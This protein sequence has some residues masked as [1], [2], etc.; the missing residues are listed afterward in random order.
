VLGNPF[1]PVVFDAACL[2]WN[3][4]TIP[5]MAQAIYDERHFDDLSILADALEES[6]CDNEALLS[7]CRRAGPHVRGCWAVDLILS[8]DR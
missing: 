7:H 2:A 8:K 3:D 6:G 5:K 1:R 4:G